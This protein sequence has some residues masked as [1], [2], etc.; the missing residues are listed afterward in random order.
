MNVEIDN[1]NWLLA[2]DYF[3]RDLEELSKKAYARDLAWTYITWGSYFVEFSDWKH[4]SSS[5]PA[6]YSGTLQFM[7]NSDSGIMFSLKPYKTGYASVNGSC[8]TNALIGESSNTMSQFIM[9]NQTMCSDVFNMS[10]YY[11]NNE[12]LNDR[13]FKIGIDTRAMTTALAINLGYSF[14]ICI[15]IYI[16]IY[17]CVCYL[18]LA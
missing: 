6:D 11:Q 18:L 10:F 2:L 12:L 4:A 15:Y 14:Y 16:Y 3:D 9:T 5:Q 1:D 17:T 13:P 8:S 7:L